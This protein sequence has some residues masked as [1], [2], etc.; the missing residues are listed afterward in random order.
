MIITGNLIPDYHDNQNI[1]HPYYIPY[2]I[3]TLNL[4][5]T[6]KTKIRL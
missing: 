4:N 5:T 2:I 1:A 6:P 3:I